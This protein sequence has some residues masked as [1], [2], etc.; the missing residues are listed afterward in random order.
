V[1]IVEGKGVGIQLAWITLEDCLIFLQL[2][3]ISGSLYFPRRIIMNTPSNSTNSRITTNDLV[4]KIEAHIRELAEA[5][6]AARVSEEMQH[7]LDACSKF[8][9][10]SLH[11]IW[12]ILITN[13]K[14]TRV[15]G[16]KRWLSLNRYV[17]KGEHGI[18]ILAPVLISKDKE[19]PIPEKTVVGFKVVYV[20][21]VAQTE[22]EPLPPPPNWKSPE[23]NVLL[24]EKLIRFAES[25]GIKVSE[26]ELR[27]EVQGVSMGGVIQI[28]PEA[29]TATLIHEIAHELMHRR[30]DRPASKA[31]REMEAEAVAFVVA[32]HLGLDDVDSPNYIALHGADSGA[33]LECLERIRRTVLEIIVVVEQDHPLGE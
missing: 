7:Y 22:G 33:I 10:Y 17:R 11:N 27:G 5:T 8:H 6:D 21:D 25:R 32:R 20:F 3:G 28:A 19:D 24:T 31:V 13:P 1:G 12:L 29:G 30:E 26:Q 4:S 16:Y 14:A 9:S 15:A 2:G 23:K 18:P